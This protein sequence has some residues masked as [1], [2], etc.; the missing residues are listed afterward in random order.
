MIVAVAV[1]DGNKIWTLPKPA[2][3]HNVL[4]LMRGLD[5]WEPIEENRKPGIIPAKGEQGFLDH[6]GEFLDRKQALLVAE[7]CKQ[8]RH[9]PIAP[10]QLY[11]E[12]LW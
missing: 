9:P 7:A 6:S 12:D 8:L 3:H 1:R 10:P 11:S 4:W 2:R 5:P